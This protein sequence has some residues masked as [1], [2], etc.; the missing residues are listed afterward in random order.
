VNASAVE[1]APRI[2]LRAEGAALLIISVF[3]YA[4]VGESWWLFAILFLAPDLSL[5][6]YLGGIRTGAVIYNAAHTLVAP[7]LVAIAG[8]LLP[9]F[10]L[11]PLAL[12][13][14]A[15]IGFDRLLG[16]GLKY[17]AGFGFTHLGRVGRDQ[18][19]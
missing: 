1:G 5:L 4:R 14:T 3:L 12:I 6:G 16:Y 13:W 15:H 18:S 8:L 10:I 17:A 11:V 7:I 2:I 9:A 19:I